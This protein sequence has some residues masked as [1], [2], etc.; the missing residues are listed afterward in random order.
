M[1]F[2]FCLLMFP[3]ATLFAITFAVPVAFI[4]A[5]PDTSRARLFATLLRL[6]LGR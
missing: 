3:P 5:A 4:E 2:A 6:A 1:R